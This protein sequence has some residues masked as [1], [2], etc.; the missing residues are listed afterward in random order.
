MSEM[1]PRSFFNSNAKS[2]PKIAPMPEA[3]VIGNTYCNFEIWP[4]G[5]ENES[6]QNGPQLNNLIK[7][8]RFKKLAPKIAQKR[9][10]SERFEALWATLSV[11]ERFQALSFGAFWGAKILR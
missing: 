2:G 4:K 8:Q 10:K 1:L 5:R 6:S 3:R 7:S 9:S 11:L